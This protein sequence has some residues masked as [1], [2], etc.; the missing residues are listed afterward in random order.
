LFDARQEARRGRD[1]QRAD[2]A[3]ARLDALGIVLEDGPKG[4]RWRRKR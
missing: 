4:T 3:R 1:F 2:E